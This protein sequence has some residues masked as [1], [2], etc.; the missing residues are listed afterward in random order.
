VTRLGRVAAV[1]LVAMLRDRDPPPRSGLSAGRAV[2][3]GAV[4]GTLGRVAAQRGARLL[5]QRLEEVPVDERAE[6]IGPQGERAT[7]TDDAMTR[8][9]ES[10][11]YVP[12]AGSVVASACASTS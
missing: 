9:E 2:A 10:S 5:R 4:G 1:V 11:K 8:S 6:G 3:I 12:C 7:S